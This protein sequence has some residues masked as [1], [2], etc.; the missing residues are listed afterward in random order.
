MG[1]SFFNRYL[2]RVATVEPSVGSP[3][4]TPKK[5]VKALVSPPPSI[6]TIEALVSQKLHVVEATVS[7]SSSEEKPLV[8][9]QKVEASVSLTSPGVE[10]LV[11]PQAVAA[12]RFSV[13]N[14]NPNVKPR[15]Y[16]PPNNFEKFK[17]T[18]DI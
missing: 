18:M 16:A 4:V 9:Q 2:N 17:D 3:Q 1:V 5:W 15:D 10:A 7:Q 14:G 12:L 13:K 6:Y 11:S 8:S